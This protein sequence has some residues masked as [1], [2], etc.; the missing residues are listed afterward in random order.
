M[1]GH[2]E[3]KDIVLIGRRFMEYCRI[4]SL[5]ETIL[6]GGKILDAASGVSSFCAEANKL[7]YKVTASDIIY[8]F[9]EEQIA[10]KCRA[11]QEDVMRQMQVLK[12]MYVWDFFNDVAALRAY[13]AEAARLF[14]EDFRK[15]GT[16]RYIAA[17]YPH[18]GFKDNEFSLSLCSHFLFMYEDR[19]DYD[20]HKQT[21]CELARITSDQIRI[22]PLINLKGVRSAFVNRLMHDPELNRFRFEIEKVDYEFMK[23][24]DEMMRIHIKI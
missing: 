14:I 24:A 11:D 20:F 8:R 6:A 3:L 12:D 19:L 2:L 17:E 21:I 16:E 23:N 22:F 13:R 18:T 9:G 10:E 5:N 1:S 7:G 15:Y 4:F